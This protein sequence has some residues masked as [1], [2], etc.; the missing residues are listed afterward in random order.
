[1]TPKN[2]GLRC[3]STSTSSR[4]EERAVASPRKRN[5]RARAFGG[6]NRTRGADY[7]SGRLWLSH[8]AFAVEW[9]RRWTQPQSTCTPFRPSAAVAARRSLS[10]RESDALIRGLATDALLA[11]RGPG[12]ATYPSGRSTSQSSSV[13]S[14][15]FL[16]R[17]AEIRSSR[18][19]S[20][21]QRGRGPCS[22]RTGSRSTQPDG[23]W[24]RE[25]PRS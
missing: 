9:T 22:T 11:A 17:A 25:S 15:A 20:R 2:G 10:S 18:F 8:R 13:T 4:Q 1:M 24:R 12:N 7:D 19:A 3:S 23:W 5:S 16:P 21:P 14:A 6:A